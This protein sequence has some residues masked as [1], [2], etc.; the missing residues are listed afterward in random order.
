MLL[1]HQHIKQCKTSLW[2]DSFQETPRYPLTTRFSTGNSLA[3]TGKGNNSTVNE[4]FAIIATVI[5]VS[6]GHAHV[7]VG[8]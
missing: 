6:R 7:V 3:N 5:T 8:R 4:L 2:G 1:K